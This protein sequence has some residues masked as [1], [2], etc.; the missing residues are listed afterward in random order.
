[1][2]PL[3]KVIRAANIE[4]KDWIDAMHEFILAYR[5]TPHSSTSVAPAE[6]M[7]QRH[8]RHTL[9]AILPQKSITTNYKTQQL[10]M[11]KK[12]NVNRPNTQHS[13]VTQNHV[14]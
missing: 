12:V 8:I 7:F 3:T 10:S 6:L 4:R 14:H 5:V 2:Q 9:P 11:T 1:M 13:V